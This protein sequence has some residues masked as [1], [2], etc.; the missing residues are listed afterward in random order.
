M[1]IPSQYYLN[2]PRLAQQGKK[3]SISDIL[4]QQVMNKG[5]EMVED[6]AKKKAATYLGEQLGFQGADL[7]AGAGGALTAYDLLTNRQSRLGG[8]VK[9][10]IAGGAIGGPIGAL[11][12]GGLG[13][14][15]SFMN[16]GYSKLEEDKRKALMKNYGVDLGGVKA[17]ENNP[18]FAK[19]RN[20]SDLTGGDINSAAD[21]YLRFGPGYKDATDAVRTQIAQEALNRGL[22]REHNGGIELLLDK[23]KGGDYANFAMGLLNKPQQS[24]TTRAPTTSKK[25]EKKERRLS[26]SEIMPQF[27]YTPQADN[28]A[29]RDA[30]FQSYLTKQGQRANKRV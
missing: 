7:L 22:V 27:S 4:G 19:S 28:S 20:E 25:K 13:F 10:A 17:W 5:K 23:D 16:P 29:E 9:G 26:L 14:A 2:D 11:V 15:S 12:G 1:P 6:E 24:T 30:L 3:P 21:F 8:T 18:T